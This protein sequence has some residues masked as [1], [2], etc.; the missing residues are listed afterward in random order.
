MNCA[1]NFVLLLTGRIGQ[2]TR[3]RSP[4]HVFPWLM[5]SKSHHM[6][7]FELLCLTDGEGLHDG[8]HFLFLQAPSEYF[9]ICKQLK[10]LTRR[11]MSAGWDATRSCSEPLTLARLCADKLGVVLST[12]FAPVAFLVRLPVGAGASWEMSAGLLQTY[13]HGSVSSR[14][15]SLSTPAYVRCPDFQVIWEDD[16]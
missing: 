7:K 10:K 1:T 5:A 4:L 14:P 11:Q 16:S 3:K 9:S 8:G 6:T 15:L 13:T 2:R 12:A